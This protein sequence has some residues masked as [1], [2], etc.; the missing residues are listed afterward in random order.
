MAES[1]IKIVQKV[2]RRFFIQC[3]EDNIFILNNKTVVY[4]TEQSSVKLTMFLTNEVPASNNV[5]IKKEK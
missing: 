2:T 4:L 5:P 1:K 3:K